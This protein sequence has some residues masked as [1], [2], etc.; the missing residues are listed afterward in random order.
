MPKGLE[1]C[2]PQADAAPGVSALCLSL[3]QQ[4]DLKGK[5]MKDM[6]LIEWLIV[7]AI[8]FILI[9][10]F[11]GFGKNKEKFQVV[12]D[13]AHGTTVYDGRQYQ[14]VKK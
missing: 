3:A 11:V 8:A 4:G 7:A 6:T 14:C 2:P 5:T 10:V 13:E 12:C 9:A 1:L